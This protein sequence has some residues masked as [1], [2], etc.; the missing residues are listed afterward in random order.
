MREK[1]AENPGAAMLFLSYVKWRQKEL[2][3]LAAKE[4]PISCPVCHGE[5]SVECRCSCCDDAHARTC[6]ECLGDGAALYKYLSDKAIGKLVSRARYD[7][8]VLE[9]AQ[10]LAEWVRRDVWEILVDSGFRPWQPSKDSRIRLEPP[11][12]ALG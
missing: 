5:G 9:E 7:A 3:S 11:G 2:E 1:P 12:W 10:Q 4:G 8:L 6:P